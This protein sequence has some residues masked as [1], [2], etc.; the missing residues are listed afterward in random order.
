M[1]YHPFR[2]L[3]LKFLSVGVALGLWFT[4]AGERDGRAR[5][6]S[7][8]SHCSNHPER[9]EL[10]GRALPGTVDVRVRGRSGSSASCRPGAVRATLDLVARQGRPHATST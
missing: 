5:R 9:L 2:H 8:R 3:G 6:W 1:A 4:V 7:C 10:V